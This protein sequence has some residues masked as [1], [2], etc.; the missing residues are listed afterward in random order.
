M[1]V[2]VFARLSDYVELYIKII[3]LKVQIMIP[4][5]DGNSE[6]GGH[7]SCKSGNLI[8]LMHLIR[9]TELRNLWLYFQ[10]WPVFLYVFTT[11]SE[12][13]SYNCIMLAPRLISKAKK[14]WGPKFVP[15]ALELWLHIVYCKLMMYCMLSNF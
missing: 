5:L 10:R 13:P 7:L 15:G 1:L 8:C 4:I 12:L 11:C 14:N 9:S 3:S 2:I 6:I